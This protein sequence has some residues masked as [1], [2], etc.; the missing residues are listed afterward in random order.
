MARQYGVSVRAFNISREQI[1]YARRR[2]EREGLADRVA[3]IEDDYRNI[4]GTCDVFV[5]VGML[6]HVGREYYP[7]FGEVIHR[8]LD[9]ERGRGLLHFIGRNWPRPLNAW[10]RQRIFPAPSRRPWPRLGSTSSSRG[11]WRCWTWKTCGFTMRGPWDT[12][13]R[14]SRQRKTGCGRCSTIVF[15]ARGGSTWQDRGGLHDRN[16]AAV[17]SHLCPQP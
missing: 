6:E 9:P 14:A 13:W 5:S 17:S 16:D 11:T 1:A 15:S 7:S 10:I 8:V 2:A 3:F 4:T 12:G